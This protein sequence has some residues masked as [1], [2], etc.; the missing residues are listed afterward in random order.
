MHSQNLWTEWLTLYTAKMEDMVDLYLLTN[1]LQRDSGDIQRAVLRDWSKSRQWTIASVNPITCSPNTLIMPTNHWR[2]FQYE[3]LFEVSSEFSI[4]TVD[5]IKCTAI[6]VTITPKWWSFSFDF[7]LWVGSQ[8][9]I[10]FYVM[11]NYSLRFSSFLKNSKI[12][13][14]TEKVHSIII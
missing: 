4:S 14:T 12:L 1:G 3:F 11:H 8:S 13:I 7:R 5:K 10:P 2:V 6:T 9:L